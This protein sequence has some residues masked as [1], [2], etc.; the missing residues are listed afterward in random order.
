MRV[1]LIITYLLFLPFLIN[2][3][4]NLKDMPQFR[5]GSDKLQIP[6]KPIGEHFST[7]KTNSNYRHVFNAKVEEFKEFNIYL[8][9]QN[10]NYEIETYNLTSKKDF[11]LQCLN[12]AINTLKTLLKVRPLNDDYIILDK[13][14]QECGIKKWDKEKIGDELFIKKEGMKTL[15]IDLYIFVIFEDNNFLGENTLAAATSVFHSVSNYQPLL[16]LIYINKDVNYEKINSIQYL[17]SVLIHECT[18][19]L[20]F[21]KSYFGKLY[22]TFTQINEYGVERHYIN[23][24]RVLKVARKY[25]NCDSLKGVELEE[26]GGDGTVGSHW[27]ERI[28]L[29]EYMIG[30]IYPI[31]EVISE[32]TL[33][34]LE[35]LGYYKAN[36]YTG[37]LMKYGKNKGCDFLNKKCVYDGKITFKN[38]F[39]DM[40]NYGGEACTSGRQSK[41]IKG[42]FQYQ[43]IPEQYQYFENNFGGRSSADYCPVFVENSSEEAYYVG[44]CSEIGNIKSETNLQQE[45]VSESFSDI[46][47]CALSSLISKSNQN[48]NTQEKPVAKCYQMFCSSESLTIKINNDFIVCPRSGG[49]INVLN[50][51][52][53]LLCPDYNLICSGTVVCNDMFECVE[54]K[55]LLKDVIYDYEIQT[56]QD[57]IEE[58]QK[59][60]IDNFY[61]LSTNG[62]CLQRCKQCNDLH[63][64]TNCGKE[65]GLLE[66]KENNINKRECRDLKELNEGY[67]KEENI[68]RKCMDNCIDCSTSNTCNKC[69]K[70]Y[71]LSD[72]K[73]SCN[74]EVKFNILLYVVIPSVTVSIGSVLI[75]IGLV[76]LSLRGKNLAEDVYHISFIDD[77]D[78]KQ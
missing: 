36:Y 73:D 64:C 66:Y 32:F 5:C 24:T 44:H 34:L 1:T 41:A 39:F 70:G 10:F 77:S 55:S 14:L 35:D 71:E 53:Y 43:S 28:L 13:N 2:C 12:K 74:K 27:E 26:Y 65:F 61:E 58:N 3:L 30:V 11:F 20:G 78:R 75:I 67:Y 57:L 7:N 59:D 62:K 47:F 40:E 56:S 38:E 4:E 22:M 54:K 8:D 9:L 63:K 16:G 29:G 51:D 18:H 37:G 6:S 19:I 60:F 25:Y 42:L 17:S 45:L 31:E 23:S 15:G 21:S 76:K 52:G 49:K 50:Y 33:A 48:A 68:Y 46:S 69:S 72:K